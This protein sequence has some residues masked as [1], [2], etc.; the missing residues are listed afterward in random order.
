MKKIL[1]ILPLL[2]C[3]SASV[4]ASDRDQ[5]IRKL[6]EAQGLLS[7]FEQQLEM[8]KVQSDKVG[9]QM[10][11]QMLSQL[12]PNEEFKERFEQAFL[13]FVGKMETPWT[14]KEIVSVWGEHYGSEFSN[15]DLDA[16]IK[17][18]ISDIGQK[19][20]KASK[21][22]LVKFTEHFQKL[23]EPIMQNAMEEYVSEL[24]LAV[25]ECDCAR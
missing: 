12:N 24:K 9:R 16:L 7:M 25:K 22:A 21:V 5:K 2:F 19:E 6:M 23:G 1:I 11:D 17:F 3:I 15:E 8:G 20:V 18:Y 4:L 10:L 14:A 13:N